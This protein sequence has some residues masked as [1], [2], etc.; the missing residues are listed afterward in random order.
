MSPTPLAL[1]AV[2]ASM[3]FMIYAT[4][5]GLHLLI[6][7]DEVLAPDAGEEFLLELVQM[8]DKLRRRMFISLMLALILWTALFLRG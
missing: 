2:A 4:A 8:L 3:Y 5:W 7:R 6:L 1:A